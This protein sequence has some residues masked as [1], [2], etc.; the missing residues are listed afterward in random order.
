VTSNSPKVKPE[1]IMA[2]CSFDRTVDQQFSAKKVGKELD[3]YR[4]KGAGPTARMLLDGLATIDLAQGTLLDVGGGVGALTFA[5]IERGVKRAVI[6]EASKAYLEAA[7][8]EAARRG[9]SETVH[10]VRGDFL[11]VAGRVPAA[12]VVTLDRVICCYPMYAELLAESLSHA[13]RLF[14][15]SYPR[16]RWYVRGAVR[17]ENMLRGRKSRFQ[18]FVHPQA[19]M[20]RLI[21]NA[22]FRL[23]SH[24]HTVSW[25]G[26]VFARDVDWQP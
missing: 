23:V 4:R 22:G 26:D 1:R 16:D 12:T 2:C 19:A 24:A 21:E 13:E 11:D 10:V 18:T 20:Q 17:V 5:L 6:V 7:A 3:R 9:L 25:C 14:A 15:Y 8:T